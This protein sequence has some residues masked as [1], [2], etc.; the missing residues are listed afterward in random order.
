MEAGI[1]GVSSN[2]AKVGVFVFLVA[3]LV[4]CDAIKRVPDGERLL[5]KNKIFVDSLKPSNPAVY[6][7]AVQKPNQRLPLLNTP[8]RLHIYN[9]ARPNR[10]SIFLNWIKEKPKSYQFWKSILS[11]KQ[12]L[13]YG[14]NAVSFNN[15]I[16]RTG[17]APTLIDEQLVEKSKERLSAWYWNRG[18]FNNQVTHKI[19]DTDREKRVEAHYYV[20]L[21][22]P[23]II[24]SLKKEI[25]S[26]ALDSLYE[27]T[28]PAS[29]VKKGQQYLS[30]LFTR[31][32]DRLFNYFKN[33]GAYH[34]KK[35]NVRFEG[36]SVQTGYKVNATLLIGQREIKSFDT[37]LYEPFKVH[38]ISKINIYPDR[39]PQG[40][41]SIIPDTVSVDGY[42]IIRYNQ[43]KYR[44]SVFTNAVLFNPG[45][46]YRDIDRN[47][48]YKRFTELRS[49]L[50]PN[51]TYRQDPADSTGVDLISDI[52]LISRQKF[53]F[54]FTPEATH[55]NIQAFG[56]GLN[57]SLLTR[58]VFGGSELLDISFRGN[59]GASSNSANG[60]SRFFDLQELGAD[61]KLIFP[62]IFVPFKTDSLI[63]KY[64][65]PSS[66]L[67]L[68]F[69]SQTNIGLDKQSVNAGLSYNWK[70][71]LTK[72]TRLDLINMQYVRNLDPDN[73][74]SVYQS[75]YGSLND[76]ARSINTTDPQYVNND[77]NLTIPDG[78]TA[79]IRDVTSGSLTA[80]PLLQQQVRNIEER[81]NRL[82][83][84]NLIIS[85]SY[86]WVRNNREGIYD[87]DFSRIS[88]RIEVA[89]NV[90]NGLANLAGVDKNSDGRREVF[91]VEFSQYVKPEVDY[92]KHWQYAN[93]HVLAIRAYGGV[94]IPY[95]NSDNIPFIRSFFAGGP[96]DNRAWQ[97]YELGP[98]AT[99]GVN[100]FN[101][102]NMKLAFNA[103]YRFPL[104]GAFKGAVF[105]DAGNIWNVLDSE[106]DPAAIFNSADDLEEIAL[107]TGFGI[108]YDFGFF[109]LRFDAGFK[110]YNPARAEGRRW[111]TQYNFSQAV[112][113]VGI[114]YPF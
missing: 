21:G 50:A 99:G 98:G 42:N 10:D 101:E 13:R 48:T 112:L 19:K 67:S 8:L 39:P 95:G 26:P 49:F 24:D 100:D 20:D 60:D 25:E 9:Q 32:R 46:I 12:L 77:L 3:L 29:L 54:N 94:A 74:F 15:W 85:S 34:L 68:G 27:L 47:R 64:M 5:V 78:T 65:S 22:K 41:D 114:N 105:A 1:M 92:I 73:F 36:D 23:Y 53:E 79:F 96:N 59:I 61:A 89:G 52:F 110:T 57:T 6:N 35:E 97:A 82:S 90:I 11:E 71:S 37:T 2:L 62:R 109:V 102:A 81:R 55:S 87:E 17:E 88:I 30:P 91:G 66:E 33:H 58:N 111:F 16:K 4:S 69:F 40:V 84:D 107:G 103:E 45:K 72:S 14:R 56:L 104:A 31:E 106:E 86:N 43:K 83:Q 44:E 28:R 108:R 80:D 63:P 93:S 18:Y 75:S 7:L 51:I 70:Q 38:K 76:I 113:N